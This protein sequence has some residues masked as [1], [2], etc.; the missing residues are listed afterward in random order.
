MH[1]TVFDIQR[2]SLHDG[3]G[4][5]TTV[6]L[7]GCS[8]RCFWCH[9]PESIRRPPEIEFY[10][11]R[12][13]GCGACVALCEHGANTI[14]DDGV[15]TYDPQQCTVC[16][17]CI[18]DCFANARVLVGRAWSVDEVMAEILQ[19]RSF[20]GDEGGVTLSGGEPMLQA[21]F[22]AALLARC[23]AEDIHTAI[24][25]AG[26]Y[27][28]STLEPVLPLVDLVMMD[29]KHL[30]SE[31]H[32]D[33]TGV[34]NTHILSTARHLATETDKPLLFRTPVIPT[35]N[36]APEVIDR[37]AGFVRDLIAARAASCAVRG[38]TPAPVRYQ[39]LRFHQ[40]A[41]DKYRGLGRAN[42]A[43]DLEPLSKAQ[44]DALSQRAHAM[45][46]AGDPSAIIPNAQ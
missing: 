22:T 6:F 32:R 46:H 8:L 26:H 30:D 37:I 44:M 27:P 40:L 7:K 13:I 41:G 1:G 36:D 23:R 28:W 2:F 14:T 34:P 5:R 10:P 43:R 29:L 4:I 18:D 38:E 3:P 21:D 11:E 42:R 16:G 35:Y 45:I 15:V 12:C 9:N 24:E 25:T 17:E 31:R 33:G 39:L 20:Y 19:D